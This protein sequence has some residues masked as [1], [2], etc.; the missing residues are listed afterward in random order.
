[1][2]HP[3]ATPS[4]RITPNVRSARIIFNNVFKKIRVADIVPTT[5]IDE[6]IK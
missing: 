4:C 1:M 2:V 6:S 3:Y 5:R